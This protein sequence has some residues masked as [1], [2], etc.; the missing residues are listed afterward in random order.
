[1]QYGS[2]VLRFSLIY[3]RTDSTL[4]KE[5]RTNNDLQST[6]F[7]LAENVAHNSPV[8]V[9]MRLYRMDNSLVINKAKEGGYVRIKNYQFQQ[10]KYIIRH[11]LVQNL[12][13]DGLCHFE[14]LRKV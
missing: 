6:I 13:R 2:F 12:R 8:H 14:Q 11:I 4:A 1:V 3:L 7:T 10:L 9:L 5:K